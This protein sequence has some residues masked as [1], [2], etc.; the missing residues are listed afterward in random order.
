M[1]TEKIDTQAINTIRTLSMDAV[2]KAHSGHPGAPMALAP[3]AYQLWQQELRYDPATPNW[4]DRDRFIL[5]NGHASMLLY[6]LLHLAGVKRV[7][8]AKVLD[9]PAV[10][11]DDIRNFRQLDS[12]TPGH[13]EYHW[14]TGVETTTGPLGAGV[15]NSVGMAIASKWLGA[16]FNKPGF[17]LFTHDVYALCGD[18]DMMEGVASEAAS[19]AGHLKLPNL[20]WIYDSNHIS[21]DGS[22]DLAFT[23]DVGRRFEG[24]GWR[25]LKVTDANDLDALSKAYKS[26]KDERGKPT[27]IIVNSFIGFGSPKKQGSASAHGEPLGADEIK[28]TKKAYGWPE[29]AQFLVPDGVR[30][31]FQ[32]R[33]GARGKALHDAWEKSLADY[34]KQHPE[35]ARELDALLKRELPEGWDKELPVFP[36]DAKGMATRES[37]GKVLNAL[38]KNYPWLVGGS[39]DLN[40]STKTYISSSTSLKP[41]EY[42]GR[43]IHFGVREHAMGS[44]VNGLNLSHVRGYGATFL[45]FSDYERPAMRLSSLMEIPSI[46][47]FTHDS[48]GLGEDGPT[49]QPVEQLMSLRAVPGNIVLRPGDANEVTEAWR[50]IAQQQHHPVVL[51]LSRQPV[52]TLDR[53]KFAPASG[54]AKGA[55]TLLE[56]E[57]GT[58]DVILIGT[59]TEVALVVEAA[60]KLKAEGVKARVVSMPSWEL[61]EQQPQDYQDS[62]LPPGVKARVAVEK[63]AAFGWERWTG[64]TGSIIGMR[65]FG[66]SAPIKALQQKFG[67]TVE[68]VVKEAH[69]T[70]AKAKKH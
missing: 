34:R 45:I 10:S 22:T 67:F 1:T 70:I 42:S 54:V 32:E 63:G 53:T 68:N 57:G 28:A 47:I 48:I 21:I 43:N 55:Y 37:G 60:E 15:S 7:K 50:Y 49:H 13:P 56:A 16:H 9:V 17:D 24:Y 29:D 19:L 26:F 52:P 44:V 5:S 64:H 69:A 65:S 62:V 8:D 18:G 20:C 25:V 23:E 59:G 38:A 6:S 35:L 58:P 51:V 2:E 14:T 39:A 30:E 33:M 36:A 40:P 27:L 66:A 31:R 11:L 41:G 12:A 61:F 3:V 4:P 46:H